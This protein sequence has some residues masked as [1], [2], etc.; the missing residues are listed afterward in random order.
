[1]KMNFFYSDRMFLISAKPKK[2]P[3]ASKPKLIDRIKDKVVTCAAGNT[4]SA[5][6]TERGHLYMFGL[7]AA[8]FESNGA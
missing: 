2:K 1:M 3:T 8:P 4:T 6:V 5:F 7:L